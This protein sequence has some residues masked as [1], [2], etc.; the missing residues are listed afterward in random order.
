[1]QRNSS[2]NHFSSGG[3]LV[4]SAPHEA[5]FDYDPVSLT[6]RGLLTEPAATNIVS[7]SHAST[8]YWTGDQCTV[9]DLALSALG[10]FDGLEVDS[11]AK[12]W[13][14]ARISIDVAVNPQIAVTAYY[15]LG[16]SGS[17]RFRL[18]SGSQITQFQGYPNAYNMSRT[19]LGTPSVITD[20]LLA[21]GLTRRLC[22]LLTLPNTGSYTIGLGANSSVSGETIVLLGM[23]VEEGAT[24]TSFITTQGSSGQRAADQ[25]TFNNLV[26]TYDFEVTY[27][28]GFTTQTGPVVVGPGYVLPVT[29]G[30]IQ[31]VA[32]TLL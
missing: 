3:Q 27:A 16:S 22:V 9:S 32:A 7:E 28:E 19:D 23:Q 8:T 30:H 6:L 13:S 24:D 29:Q 11:G 18:N 4:T 14:R 5:R 2:A 26:G 21:D 25:V 10:Q 20:D 31:S 17:L 15:R 1:M 12:A